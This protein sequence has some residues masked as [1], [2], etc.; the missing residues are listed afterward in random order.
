MNRG[1]IRQQ[2]TGTRRG[3]SRRLSPVLRF[4]SA[5]LAVVAVVLSACQGTADAAA[6]SIAAFQPGETLSYA[7]SWSKIVTAG[8]AEM[9]VGSETLP[10]G[11]PGLKFV[12]TADSAGVVE[13]FFRT[14]ERVESVFDP[15]I[16]QSLSFSLS[17][18]QG[19]KRRRRT[20]QF[21][22][23]QG[24]VVSRLNDDPPK[25]ASVPARIQDALS[26]IYYLRTMAD[27]PLGGT[28]AIAVHDS[29]KTWTI[30]FRTLA[31]E[32]VKTPSGLFAT[33][34]ISTHPKY[35]G[36]FMSKGEVIFWLTDDDRRIP[37]LA[38]IYADGYENR[39]GRALAGR[40]PRRGRTA[41][42]HLSIDTFREACYSV[43]R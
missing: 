11:K 24:T 18:V 7:I 39:S 27:F 5:A 43:P 2:E 38:G 23:E 22:P 31:K 40:D 36:V 9:K 32:T 4:F 28:H 33:I 41:S 8:T 17:E 34:K 1:P 26:S 10:D 13:K 20:L 21:D 30:E 42:F 25:T 37:V 16:M 6:H 15:E 19:K 12:T 3:I 14:R 29:G 35:D